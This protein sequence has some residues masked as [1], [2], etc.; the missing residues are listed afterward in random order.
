MVQKHKY[1]VL[2][3]EWLATLTAMSLGMGSNTGQGTGTCRYIVAS[4]HESTL[5][6]RRAAILLV[7]LV[8]G[9]RWE[10]PDHPQAVLP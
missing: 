4:R 3:V 1:A 2:P 10:S 8:E 5:K 6:S 7:R 9:E